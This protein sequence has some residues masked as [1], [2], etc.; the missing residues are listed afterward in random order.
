MVQAHI[1]KLTKLRAKVNGT[2]TTIGSNEVISERDAITIEERK[3]C[4][5]SDQGKEKVQVSSWRNF[6][7]AL[8]SLGSQGMNLSFIALVIKEGVP[9]A[10]VVL[11]IKEVHKVA[12]LLEFV[13]VIPRIIS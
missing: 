3:E 4:H 10:M 2:I 13:V 12:N 5:Q 6:F 11:K 9:M 7:P 8:T 1:A